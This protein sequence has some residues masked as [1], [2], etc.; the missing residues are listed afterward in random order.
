FPR[1]RVPFETTV[2]RNTGGWAVRY[3]YAS[4]KEVSFQG[5]SG[6]RIRAQLYTP[7]RRPGAPLL[8]HVKRAV[9]SVATSDVDELLPLMGR[10]TTLVLNPRST[11]QSMTPAEYADMERS[12]VWVGRTL[13]AAQVWDT[14]RAVEWAAGEG[15]VAASSIALYGKGEMGIVC[16]YAALFDER[17]KLVVLDDPP[18]SH[19]RGPALL[20]VPRGGGIPPNVGAPPAPPL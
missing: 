6:V 2:T 1:E 19:R 11:E 13:A 8:I 18:G 9:D 12:S 10:Y 16:L 7:P 5:E 14:L 15:K 4:F 17:I 3:G 20:N